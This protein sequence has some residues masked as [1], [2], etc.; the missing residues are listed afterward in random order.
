MIVLKNISKVFDSKQTTVEAL[1]D[2]NLTIPKG[3]I[4]GI[5]GYS[6]AGKSTLIRMIN[7]L[8]KPTTGKVIVGGID[9]TQVKAK[10]LRSYR[11]KIG[12]I[13]QQFHLMN[14]RNVFHNVAYPLKGSGLSDDEIKQKVKSLLKLVELEDKIHS[15][16]HQLSGGQKQRVAIARALA[17]DP[18]ILLCDEATSALDPQT[19]QSILNLLKTINQSLG[20]TIVLITHEMQV[21]KDICDQVAV[22]ENGEIKETG[23]VLD[24]FSNP[25]SAITKEFVS[26]IFNV[27]YHTIIGSQ[28]DASG[29]LMKLTFVGEQVKEAHIANV[30]KYFDVEANILFGSIENIQQTAFGHLI[31]LFNGSKKAIFKVIEYLEQQNIL[32]EEVRVC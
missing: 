5:I 7:L 1:K 22:M 13:F 18:D 12:M 25:Q 9:L 4:F 8:E 6:G 32:V 26:T 30:V 11:K 3:S 14:S 16:P 21:I 20:I 2:I 24:I 27:D 15:Y 10:E 31:V 19:T 28:L 17:N 23:L 29:N